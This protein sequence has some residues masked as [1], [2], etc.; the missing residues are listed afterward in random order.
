MEHGVTGDAPL[1]PMSGLPD[2]EDPG[3]LHDSRGRVSVQILY[4]QTSSV[5][6]ASTTAVRYC[7][8]IVLGIFS[9]P[10]L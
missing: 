5:C 3:V 9:W 7:Y 1:C 10:P 6:E 8:I 4:R 2:N